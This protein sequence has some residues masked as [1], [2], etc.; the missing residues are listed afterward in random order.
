MNQL[1]LHFFPIISSF[2]HLSSI[3]PQAAVQSQGTMQCT[4]TVYQNMR[5]SRLETQTT[6]PSNVVKWKTVLLGQCS[7]KMK[8][9]KWFCFSWFQDSYEDQP[10]IWIFLLRNLCWLM[11]TEENKGVSLDWVRGLPCNSKAHLYCFATSELFE[12]VYS[13]TEEPTVEPSTLEPSTVDP[14]TDDDTRTKGPDEP[15]TKEP[16]PGLQPLSDSAVLA[17]LGGLALIAFSC[18]T[19]FFCWWEISL[20]KSPYCSHW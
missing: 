10:L 3:F 16:K 2:R 12:I 8:I 20:R 4:K 5:E 13:V 11:K 7:S 18:L 17:L 1:L 14:T 19:A 6:V 15:G 9:S